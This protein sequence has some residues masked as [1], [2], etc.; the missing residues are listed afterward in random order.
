MEWRLGLAT[1]FFFILLGLVLYIAVTVTPAVRE[2]PEEDRPAEPP[3]PLYGQLPAAQWGKY[4]RMWDGEWRVVAPLGKSKKL[5]IDSSGNV[6]FPDP[7][8]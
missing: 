1:L 5:F 6:I 3:V 7:D 4:L 2:L 8:T